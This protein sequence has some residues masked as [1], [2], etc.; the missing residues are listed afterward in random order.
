VTFICRGLRWFAVWSVISQLLA[1]GTPAPQ[2]A[3][4]GDWT[5][6]SPGVLYA[7][8]SPVANSMVHVVRVDLAAVRFEVSAGDERGQ[9]IDSM[10]GTQRSVVSANASFFDRNF[11]PRGITVSNGVAWSAV[12][13]QQHSP[14]LAC[15]VQQ[16]CTVVLTPPFELK[17]AWHNVVAGTP[18][19]VNQGQVRTVQDDAQCKNLCETLHPRTAVGLDDTTRYL[20]IVTAEGRK[21]PVLGLSLVQ[22]SRIMA[23]LGVLNAVNLDGGGSSTLFVQGHAV[24][25]RPANEPNQRKVANA[26]HIFGR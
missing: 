26:I 24:M 8:R 21:P 12:M 25:D 17:P 20:F 4:P 14:L 15:D 19:L 18:W 7:K 2:T 9:T 1:C 11:Q 6:V 13:S 10:A 16:H 23:D 5:I 3:P 22:L